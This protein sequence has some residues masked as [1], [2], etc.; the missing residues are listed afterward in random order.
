MLGP[1]RPLPRTGARARIALFGGGFQ[2]ATVLA[3]HDG[4]RR[5]E[6]RSDSGELLEFVL[7]PATAAFTAAGGAGG[8]RLQLLDRD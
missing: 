4:G 7:N 2:T 5:L 1:S 3:V 6:V 8:P